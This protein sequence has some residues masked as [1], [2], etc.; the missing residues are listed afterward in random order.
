MFHRAIRA[1]LPGAQVPSCVFFLLLTLGASA[2][3]YAAV[4]RTPGTS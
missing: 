2:P 4:G 3:R 1:G